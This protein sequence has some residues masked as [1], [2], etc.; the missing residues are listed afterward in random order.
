[1][2]NFALLSL[3]LSLSPLLGIMMVEHNTDESTPLFNDRIPGI[4]GHSYTQN[5]SNGRHT[6][7]SDAVFN[8]DDY[9]G[10]PVPIPGKAP[11]GTRASSEQNYS[12][13]T[14]TDDRTEYVARFQ[15]VSP[16]RFWFIFSG[17]LV[18][19]VVAF[20]DATLMGSIHPVITSYFKASNA[21]SWLSTAFLL[22]STAFVPLF[23]QVSDTFG[24]KPVYLF[25]IAVVFITTLWCA[26]AQSIG[27]IIAARAV[28][29]LGAGGVLSLGMILSSDLVVAQY[30]GMYQSY[31]NLALGVGGCLGLAF[32]GFLCDQFGWRSAF[33][34]QLPLI[35][36]HFCVTAWLLPPDLGLKRSRADQLTVKQLMRSIDLL[37]SVL[38]IV[39]V[40]ALILG[41]NCGG[42][43]FP[44]SHPMIICSLVLGIVLA[45]TFV[46]YEWDRWPAVMS[47]SML[48]QQP[49]ASLIF[50]N[51]FASISI[52]TVMFNA[53]LYFQAV[54]LVSPTQSGLKLLIALLA[55]TVSSVTTGFYIAW[56]Q[57]L[58]PTILTGELFLVVGGIATALM[59]MDT[60]NIVA[61]VCIVFSSLG[62]GA[63]F[64][65]L[66]VSV[67]ATSDHSNQALATTTL[68]LWQCLGSVMGVSISSWIFQNCLRYQLQALVTGPNKD[69]VIR[70]VRKSVQSIADLDP[71]YKQQG[72]YSLSPLINMITIDVLCTDGLC[73]SQCV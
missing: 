32:G 73:S 24:R 70:L 2:P 48:T 49:H 6:T 16:V 61:I 31:I 64:D 10:A 11:R 36:V 51:F 67:F 47:F 3:L 72:A 1:M 56:S 63:A 66:I 5:N 28:C 68:N 54:K 35:F 46:F 19:Y 39:S 44:W 45:V 33:Y 8:P 57:R 52:N 21:A 9:D 43:V 12:E 50:G 18:G 59:G 22:T 55:V 41:L 30:C 23:G 29:G 27:S 40:A 25:S 7:S 20:F 14:A 37:G 15:D 4:R 60:P 58:K 17:I 53:P 38:L 13:A 42:N 65:S 71:S 34:V 69:N 26:C 62:Q